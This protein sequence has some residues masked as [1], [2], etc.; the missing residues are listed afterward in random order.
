MRLMHRIGTMA[1]S[2]LKRAVRR[3]AWRFQDRAI[4]VEQPAMIAAAY[5]LRADQAELQR[6]AT[7]RA[8]ALEQ[9]DG[10][11]AVAKGHQFLTQNLHGQ[12]QVLQLIRVADRL[13]EATHVLATRRI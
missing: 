5:S 11:A 9:A 7:V 1:Q 8:M 10:A 12:R 2:I 3:L 13:P 6:R 4:H